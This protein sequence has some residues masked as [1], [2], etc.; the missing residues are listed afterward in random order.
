MKIVADKNTGMC[1][2]YSRGKLIGFAP[3]KKKARKFAVMLQ[4]IGHT[5]GKKVKV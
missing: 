2:F 3:N 5:S 4:Q 1:S